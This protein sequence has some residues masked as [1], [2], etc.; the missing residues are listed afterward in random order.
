MSQLS[1]QYSGRQESRRGKKPTK[2]KKE[3]INITYISSPTMVKAT[4]GNCSRIN[5]KRFQS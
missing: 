5:R 2:H 3:P 4:K 1:E